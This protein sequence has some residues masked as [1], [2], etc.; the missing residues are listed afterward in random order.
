MKEKRLENARIC[1][2]G[3]IEANWNKA[4]GFIPKDKEIIIYKAD[5]AHPV[6]R[7]KIGDGVTAVQDLDFS[8]ADMVAIEQ[9]V[10]EK[11]ELL[12]EYVLP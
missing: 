8:G 6:A 1:P 7:F 9:L 4:I 10:N 2:K 3:D 11:G 12:I 5:A